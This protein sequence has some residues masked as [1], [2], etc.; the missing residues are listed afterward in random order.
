VE[1]K[2]ITHSSAE[3]DLSIRG[4]FSLS[5]ASARLVVPVAEADRPDRE[6]TLPRFRH[7]F[8]EDYWKRYPR[9]TWHVFVLP[10]PDT[11]GLVEVHHG[12]A[13]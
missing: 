2:T 4:V 9:T 13:K 10:L 7:R 1:R 12:F 8:A 5:A 11:S 3:C 6:P